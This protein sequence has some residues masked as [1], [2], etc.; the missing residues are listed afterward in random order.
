MCYKLPIVVI[1]HQFIYFINLD[2]PSSECRIV[3]GTRCI[4]SPPLYVGER[5]PAAY[6]ILENADDDQ[7]YAGGWTAR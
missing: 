2:N 7:G 3:H 1:P 4:D 5:D 6:G